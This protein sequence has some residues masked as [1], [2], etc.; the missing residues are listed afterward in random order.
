MIVEKTISEKTF[1]PAT[2]EL[3]LTKQAARQF[4][5]KDGSEKTA[6]FGLP[7]VFKIKRKKLLF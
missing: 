6:A 7:L 5:G 4:G 2:V 3:D 1:F